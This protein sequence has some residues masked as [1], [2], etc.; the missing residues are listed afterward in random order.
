L[1]ATKKAEDS[2]QAVSTET[3]ES[4][5]VQKFVTSQYHPVD[6]G[7]SSTVQLGRSLVLGAMGRRTDD[8]RI[9]ETAVDLMDCSVIIR[10]TKEKAKTPV[11]HP[12][13]NSID[14]DVEGD[15]SGDVHLSQS[16]TDTVAG[17]WRGNCDTREKWRKE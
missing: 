14:S 9:F 4:L 6:E 13:P 5:E 15:G 10:T 2:Q 12:P 1:R 8:P 11:S 17:R 7:V 16:T 3:L